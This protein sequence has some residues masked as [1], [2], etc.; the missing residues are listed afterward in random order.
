MPG[1]PSGRSRRRRA[2]EGAEQACLEALVGPEPAPTVARVGA[3]QLALSSRG[4]DAGGN[5]ESV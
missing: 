4:E 5:R 1:S 3:G 2:R